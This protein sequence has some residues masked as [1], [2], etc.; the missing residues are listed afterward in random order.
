MRLQKS[1]NLGKLQTTYFD[2]YFELEVS[3]EARDR[4]SDALRLSE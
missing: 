2:V 1:E 3:R 4:Q